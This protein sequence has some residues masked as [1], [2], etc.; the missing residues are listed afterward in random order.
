VLPCHPSA[1]NT[2]SSFLTTPK[3]GTTHPDRTAQ[4]EDRNAQTRAFQERRHP[5]LSVDTKKKDLV[6]DCKNGGRQW[7]PAGQPAMVRVHDFVDRTLGKALPSGV[8]D[9]ATNQGWVSVGTDH[10]TAACAVQTVRRW[11]QPMGQPTYP[12]AT[13]LRITAASGGRN[14]RRARLWKTAVQRLA[15]DRGLRMTV[16]H[17]PPGTRKWHTIDHRL[18][19]PSTHNWRGR[20][21]VSRA[22][23]V[24]LIGRTT[25]RTGLV[26]RAALDTAALDSR[27]YATGTTVSAAELAAVRLP[28]ATFHGDW[29]YT[30]VPRSASPAQVLP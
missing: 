7:R 28:P 14:G 6:G 11:W 15:D 10:D 29:N 26:S 1:R 12:Q 13:D 3:E 18:F 25:T 24:D 22:G 17:F 19:C 20:P 23:I 4:F 27:A 30:I 2:E 21:L 16:C 5:V 9:V 8:S